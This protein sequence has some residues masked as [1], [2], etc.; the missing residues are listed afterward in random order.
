[1]SD[2]GYVL[3]FS[4]CFVCGRPFAYNPTHVPSIRWPEPDGPRQP[5][6]RACVDMANDARVAQGLAPHRVHP[7][8]YE[9]APAGEVL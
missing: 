5:L 1:M 3:A 4:P 8:A 7:D 9:P 6:C 2:A